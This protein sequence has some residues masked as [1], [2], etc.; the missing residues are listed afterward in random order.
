MAQSQETY[1]AESNELIRTALAFYNG[2][3]PEQA[4]EYCRKALAINPKDRRAFVV[5]GYVYASQDK[6]KEASEA[7]AKAIKIDPTDKEVHLLKAQFDYSRS[8]TEDA[9]KG[10]RKAIELDPKYADA[11]LL[12]G[13][14]LEH[15]VSE[16]PK[17]IAAYQTAVSLNPQL[18][19]AHEALGELL[20][21]KKDLTSAEENYR[22]SLA[23]DPRHMAGRTNLGRMLV[24]QG[25]LAEARKL[26]EGRTSDEDNRRPTF[27]VM[28]ERAEKLKR[29]EEA[30][31]QRPD[32]PAALVDLGLAVM[33]GD[34]WVLDD[35]HERAM[36][37][38]KKALALK[39]DYARA[40]Y[41]IVK[42]FIELASDADYKTA[43][44]ENKKVDAE[45]A[46]LRNLDP[47]LADEMVAYRKTYQSGL[48]AQP[49]KQ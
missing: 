41:G 45:L 2:K 4:L 17:A 5:M 15:K 11:Y 44:A 13:K 49:F 27:I 38:F 29:A 46:K 3:N 14:L 33:D 40:Q 21:G 36:V 43:A 37:H 1:S 6:L 28:L 42:V 8:A 7:V 39:P 31:S 20:E 22:K 34:S 9:L 25:R 24:E 10:A 35:R 18:F 12:L 26:W 32:D 23:L 19:Q 16:Q 48:I 30:A 47:K